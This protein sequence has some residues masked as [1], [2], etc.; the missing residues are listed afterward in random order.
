[1]LLQSEARER[2]LEA[3]EGLQVAF[4]LQDRSEHIRRS[5]GV[6]HFRVQPCENRILYRL[7]VKSLS[8]ATSPA[9][10]CCRAADPGTPRFVPCLSS[11]CLPHTRRTEANQTASVAVDA[12]DLDGFGRAHSS[13]TAPPRR[14]LRVRSR[15]PVFPSS[16]T[17]APDLDARGGCRNQDLSP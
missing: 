8:V 6:P 13:G 16:G 9:F 12:A 11:T 2:T 14:G 4:V 7:Q 1:M 10:I 5:Y 3:G 15:G 17:R